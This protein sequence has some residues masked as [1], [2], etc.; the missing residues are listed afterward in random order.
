M[1]SQVAVLF[2][3]CSLLT[4]GTA[5]VATATGTDTA[6]SLPSYPV[7]GTKRYTRGNVIPAPGGGQALALPVYHH[8]PASARY[9]EPQVP[10]QYFP[11]APYQPTADYYDDLGYYGGSDGAGSFYYRPPPPQALPPQL[12]HRRYQRNNERYTSYGLPTYRGEYKP[13]P[14]YYSH[15]PSYSYSDEH[16][17][18][19]P[20][21][22]LHEEML[23]EDER[24]RARD[25]YP[26]GQE[27]WYESPSRPDS[28]FLRNLI[29]YN[30]QLQN[31]G[32]GKVPQPPQPPAQ[33]YPDSSAEE[34]FDEYDEPEPDYE[35]DAPSAGYRDSYGYGTGGGVSDPGYG[36]T[37]NRNAFSKLS[38]LRNSM[39]RNRLED[40]EEDD[41]ADD[42]DDEDDEEVQELKSLI[43]Q[44]QQQQKTTPSQRL[45]PMFVDR[46]A[47]FVLKNQ[48]PPPPPPPPMTTTSAVHHSQK[49]QS[50]QQQQR[51]LLEQQRKQK[52]QL[53]QAKKQQL[54]ERQQKLLRTLS[55]DYQH[56][57]APP[58]APE[59]WQRDSP[60]YGA[61]A[62]SYGDYDTEYDEDDDDSWSHWDR[63][64]NVQPKKATFAS[65]GTTTAKPAG[66]KVLPSGTTTSP[67]T[68][69]K[70]SGAQHQPKPVGNGQ[71]EVVL[72]RPTSPRNAFAASLLS[73]VQAQP[74][75]DGGDGVLKMDEASKLK[76]IKS[77]KIY[78]TLKAMITMRQNLEDAD[79]R[80][81]L[82]HQ[83]QLAHIHKRF[84]SNEESL[85]QQ[86]DGLKR[87][88]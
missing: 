73:A 3:G 31:F 53:E 51:D 65:T 59:P 21:D 87:S 4:L 17:S 72:P 37:N 63:K 18:S 41:E 13:T 10:P 50:I 56:P 2:Y 71:K 5:T 16:E 26:V 61:A 49:Q 14:Y 83:K 8:L 6:S 24:E 68:T 12:P 7:F 77:S 30:Q 34:D 81:Q 74:P 43:H 82:E 75:Q 33:L 46:M 85:V 88:A 39:A 55:S 52:E 69:D 54:L 67:T 15:G 58:V 47:P 1:W 27:Q 9:Y 35:Y 57:A 64:R 76:Q 48:Q 70:P 32:R 78:D 22:D 80:Q 36:S 38:S 45:P 11:F 62:A 60:S 28:T 25:Y 29:L 23:Q 84:V 79:L 44:H 86:L 66:A 42:E 40:G 19:N 20:L